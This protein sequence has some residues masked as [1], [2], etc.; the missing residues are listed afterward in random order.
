MGYA[1][2]DDGTSFVTGKPGDWQRQWLVIGRDTLLGEP[3]FVDL[4]TAEL[5]VFTAAHGQGVWRPD[6]IAASLEDLARLQ[7]PPA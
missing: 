3:L 4:S 7:N 5:A 1:R 6:P 2:A